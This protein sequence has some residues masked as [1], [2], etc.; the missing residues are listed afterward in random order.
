MQSFKWEISKQLK[1]AMREA[2]IDN[3][4]LIKIV[5][6]AYSKAHPNHDEDMKSEIFKII[7]EYNP[8]IDIE[9]LDLVCHALNTKI[10]L[11]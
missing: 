7:D 1:M 4:T 2:N 8:N 6:E 5:D 10:T 11:G 9:I 3:F